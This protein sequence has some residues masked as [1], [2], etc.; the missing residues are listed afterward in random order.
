MTGD[1]PI[2]AD[3]P[4]RNSVLC[5]EDAFL[6]WRT[7]VPIEKINIKR[8]RLS[9]QEKLKLSKEIVERL[10]RRYAHVQSPAG[11]GTRRPVIFIGK[12]Y[13]AYTGSPSR[14]TPRD[15]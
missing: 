12:G 4:P 3:T 11:S 15:G 2:G 9:A 6:K 7:C 13:A 10:I 14:L 8:D 5:D 1:S